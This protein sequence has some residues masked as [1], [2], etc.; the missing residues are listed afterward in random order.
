[1]DEHNSSA[2]RKGQ[3]IDDNLNI[4]QERLLPPAASAHNEH[5][6]SSASVDNPRE[7][8]SGAESSDFELDDMLSDE[9]LEDDEETGLTGTERGN[10]RRRKRK[11]ARLDQRVAGDI[12]FSEDE[13]KTATRT[14]IRASLINASLIGL[15]Y[16]SGL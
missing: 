1:M 8:G 16:V 14:V 10:R 12:K 5:A 3:I 15:W 2:R 13:D 9:G 6:D 7:T 4:E 11:N